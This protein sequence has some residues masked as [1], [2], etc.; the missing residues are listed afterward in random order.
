[1]SLQ[2]TC[3]IYI[4]KASSGGYRTPSGMLAHDT[5]HIAAVVDGKTIGYELHVKSGNGYP[6]HAADRLAARVARKIRQTWKRPGKG[7]AWET[8]MPVWCGGV[9]SA[10]PVKAGL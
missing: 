9:K 1:M 8:L 4:E 7:Y 2:Q 10:N 6:Y 3:D 5:Y